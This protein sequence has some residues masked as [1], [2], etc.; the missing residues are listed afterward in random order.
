MGSLS[1]TGGRGG[2][3]AAETGG[4]VKRG[5]SLESPRSHQQPALSQL[6][7]GNAVG[8]KGRPLPLPCPEVAGGAAT[9]VAPLGVGASVAAGAPSGGALVHVLAAPQGLVEVEA[10]RADALE[11][12]QR[13]VA[14]GRT[15]DR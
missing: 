10:R 12:P 9:Q 8:Q 3:R 4:G 11:A 7:Y 2:E 14:G 13:V 5:I 6:P 15:A 1:G